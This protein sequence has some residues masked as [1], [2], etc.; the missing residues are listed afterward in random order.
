[1]TRHGHDNANA[2]ANANATDTDTDTDN[3]GTARRARTRDHG[4]IQIKTVPE[5]RPEIDF[6]E[7]AAGGGLLILIDFFSFSLRMYVGRVF[8]S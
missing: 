2:N 1:M 6:R 4:V 7:R 8:F 5:L 3:T